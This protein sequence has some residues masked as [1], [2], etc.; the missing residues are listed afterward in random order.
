MS[1]IPQVYERS[2]LTI[3]I[4]PCRFLIGMV[5]FGT[6]GLFSYIL[7]GRI[8]GGNLFP[9]TTGRTLAFHLHYEGVVDRSR[10]VIVFE[11]EDTVKEEKGRKYL[12]YEG[13][14]S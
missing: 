1:I 13:N 14:L 2:A 5:Q 6:G 8:I 7:R 10:W 4:A 11:R 9:L 3:G 12:E